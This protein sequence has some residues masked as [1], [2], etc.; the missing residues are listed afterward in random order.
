MGGFVFCRSDDED[1]FALDESL[2]ELSTNPRYTVDVPSFATL[3]YL[4]KHF[5]HII[6]DIPEEFMLDRADSSSLGKGVLFFQVA[7]FCT[8]CIL[9]RSENLPLALFEVSTLAHGSLTLLTHLIWWSKP[10]NVPA[11]TILMGKEAREVHAL[12][13]CSS[14]EYDE[15]LELARREADGRSSTP[16]P[17]ERITK[18]KIVLAAKALQCLLPNPEQPPDFSH[19]FREHS[20]SLVPGNN[21][22]W[23]SDEEKIA[24]Y[25]E[26]VV[27]IALPIPY[28]IIHLVL[29][30]N[31]FPTP[32]ESSVW[33]VCAI[34]ITISG[35]VTAIVQLTPGLTLTKFPKPKGDRFET[36]IAIIGH[37]LKLT[38]IMTP[39]L[40][41]LFFLV[42]SFRQLFY[43]I[44]AMYQLPA[45][46]IYL[47]H[48]S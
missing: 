1:T 5:P 33:V 28:G 30:G 46:A 23:S 43:L 38:I 21:A 24:D 18:E 10:H 2:F 26:A 25:N 47:P 14:E 16:T 40:S 27:M 3:I 13:R 6:T 12:L 4:L 15:A 8:N 17:R 42:E 20:Q 35:V 41:S 44:P 48:L 36:S 31:N 19:R 45:W 22:R 9:R 34:M 29:S 37:I 32:T 39:I 7:W 11:P